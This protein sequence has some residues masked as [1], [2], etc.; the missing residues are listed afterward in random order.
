VTPWNLRDRIRRLPA[1]DVI[2]HGTVFVLGALFI[3]L[4]IAAVV[5]P[6]PL[7]IPPILLGLAI[8]SLEFDFAQSLLD[9]A[10]VPAQHAWDAA[11]TKPWRTGLV[12]GGGLVLAVAAAVLLARYDL[13]SKAVE[14]A[15][16]VIT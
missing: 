14:H 11:K 12:A 1:G 2:V 3:G 9:R 6:G 16:G 5:L 8:W 13:V 15:K 10:K 7:T 4:G